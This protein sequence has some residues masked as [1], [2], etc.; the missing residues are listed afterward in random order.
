MICPGCKN[1]IEEGNR[2]PICQFDIT[3]Y[4]KL[5]SISVRLYNKGLE[6]AKNRELFGA[7]DSLSKSVEFDKTNIDARNLL[8]LVYFE[9]GQ[10]GQALTQWIISTHFQKEDNIAQKYIEQIQ[11]NAR[12]L[13]EYNDSIRMYNQAL[14]YIRQRS[15]DLAII[16]LKKSIQQSPNFIEAY[17][18]LGL[19]FIAQDEKG[20]ALSYIEKAL[21]IDMSNPKAIRYYRELKPNSLRPQINERT[22]GVAKHEQRRK[23]NTYFSPLGQIVGFIV[24]AICTTA[25][26]Y[27][28]VI[29]DKTNALNRQITDLNVEKQRLEEEITRITRESQEIIDN[30]EEEN[31]KI[32]DVNEQLNQKQSVLQEVQK[33][34]QADVLYKNNSIVD[35]A[36]LL[37][38][39][40]LTIIPEESK[41]TYDTLANKIFSEAG[42]YHYN[43]GQKNYSQ[44]DYNNA[45][46]NFEKSLLY[47]K[48]KYYSDNALYYLGRIYEDEKD[49]EK[50]KEVYQQAIN[51]YNGTDGANNSKWRLNNLQ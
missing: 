6:Q 26:L 39:I 27:I 5:K 20:K 14:E 48:D 4:K 11:N 10:V 46:I 51:Q 21:E 24:G 43:S 2:C 16:Q 3:L 18:L 29:P 38:S 23:S 7:I 19:C 40:D 44:G 41:V 13:E 30:L 15:E 9:T 31:E 28:L 8:G 47:V 35:A 50:A 45:K 12:K 22:R 36:S 34:N 32:Q 17:C 49:I 42:L 1:K 33:I 37:Y 25:L